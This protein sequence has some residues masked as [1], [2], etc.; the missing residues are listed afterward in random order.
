MLRLHSLYTFT[1]VF[2]LFYTFMKTIHV[3]SYIPIIHLICESTVS[4]AVQA[5]GPFLIP[6]FDSIPIINIMNRSFKNF[7]YI[8]HKCGEMFYGSE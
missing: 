6:I 4:K 7:P 1:I 2:I 3:D 8:H 5:N